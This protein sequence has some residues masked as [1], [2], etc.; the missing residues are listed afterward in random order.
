MELENLINEKNFY[1]AEA[2][3]SGLFGVYIHIYIYIYIYIF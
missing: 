2:V 1:G 3:C